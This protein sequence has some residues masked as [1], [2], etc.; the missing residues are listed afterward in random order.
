MCGIV[1]YYKFHNQQSINRTILETM[2]ETLKHRGPDDYGFH[3]G[4]QIGLAQSRLSIIDLSGGKQP[5]YN[6]DNSICVVFNG[7]IFN[8]IE[9]RAQLIK[10]GHIFHTK[11]DTEVI[12]H[13][14]E[15]YGTSFVNYLIGQFAI[16]LWDDNTKQL[17]LARDRVGICPLFYASAPGG[18]FLFGSE[19]KAILKYPG[20][21]AEIDPAGLNQVFT[22]WVTIPP[23]TT[24]KNISELPPGYLM[25]VS[26]S[27]VR[28]HRYWQLQFP[29]TD[30]YENKPLEYYT[31]KLKELVFDAVTIRLRADVPVASYLSGGIDSSVI[32]A[33]VKKY[34]NNNLITFSVAFS[35]PGYDEREYQHQVVNYLNTDHR[36][37]EASYKS[38]GEYFPEVVWYAEKPMIRTAPAPLYILSGLVRQNNIKVVLT[39]EGS[40]EIFGGYDIFKEDK[41]RRFW[42][43]F[44][45][46]KYRPWLF[47]KL[48]P[49]ISRQDS[50]RN[51]WQSFFKKNFTQLDNPYYSHEIRW[52]NT[53]QIK[54][55]FNK[56]YQHLFDDRDQ[57]YAELDAYLDASLHKWHPFCRAQYLEMQLFLPGYLLS[58]QG[59]RMIM[60]H[61]VEGR[62]PFLDHRV[63]EFA[64]TIPPTLKMKAL[65]EKYILKEAYKELL[66]AAI[67]KRDK[68]PYRAPIYQCFM[69]KHDNL[70]ASMFEPEMIKKYGYFD[71]AMVHRLLTKTGKAN[72]EAISARDDM[73]MVAIASL[74]LLHYHFLENSKSA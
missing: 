47:A 67:I 56:D 26:K 62:F 11:S 9:L 19:M 54:K 71:N 68:Q 58:T 66:P 12:V 18:I 21:S 20:F 60:G 40:D 13:A 6:E 17:V 27:G 50:T 43:K 32:T 10:R 7:E 31:G 52:N 57:I 36:M 1:G 48:Y 4:D 69:D 41:V 44:P 38:I 73:S 29:A 25:T 72:E 14:Y 22:L 2:I 23:R 74:Q 33:L 42:A 61:S 16:A 59:D 5:I 37:I 53:A 49:Y 15:E 51:F 45:D 28:L 8:F 24:F 65:N 34:H 55:Y 30:E 3:L 70:A 39:G 46:S 64:S 63:I 35:D